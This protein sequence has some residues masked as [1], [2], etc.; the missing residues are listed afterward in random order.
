MVEKEQTVP[1]A[2]E[3]G[4][5][6]GQAGGSCRRALQE[7]YRERGSASGECNAFK[8]DLLRASRWAHMRDSRCPYA[9]R[10]TGR[11]KIQEKAISW[12]LLA[13]AFLAIWR[14]ASRRMRGGRLHTY[15]C[16]AAASE[17]SPVLR[18][19]ADES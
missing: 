14:S 13:L 15:S 19:E 3:V 17:L 6:G 8:P 5:I 2:G 16:A 18:S 9:M 12:C 4:R 7:G 11:S 10:S 1:C